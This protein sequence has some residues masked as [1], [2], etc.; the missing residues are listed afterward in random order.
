MSPTVTGRPL[1][2]AEQQ[3]LSD[4]QALFRPAD[5]MKRLDDF[6]KWIFTSIAVVGTLGAAFSNSAFGSLAGWGKVLFGL[7]I[8]L[9]GVSL[10]AST[11]ALEPK[12]VHANPS[13]RTS[14]LNAVNENLRRRRVPIQC[15][16]IL[17]GLA[18]VAAATAP[19]ASTFTGSKKPS[20]ILG[21]ELKADGKFTGI[22]SA[23]GL[24][25]RT[26]AELRIEGGG[27]SR[28][29]FAPSTR[30]P[31]DAH[32]EVSLSIDLDN[33]RDAGSELKLSSGWAD[34]PLD[35]A[36]E[37][38][39]HAQILSIPLPPSPSAIEQ[40]KGGSANVANK[41]KPPKKESASAGERKSSGAP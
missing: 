16:A 11:L 20:V 38:L 29:S 4:L 28:L 15:A 24:K 30:K 41:T 36:K 8:L 27:D 19:L 3:Q 26:V 9:V 22:L 34:S 25:P 1:S 33:A 6:A 39:P 13:S 21:Y 5:A 31:A 17:F 40:R 37:R 23:T 10:F 14:M 12:W 2:P 7:A 18:L 32:G 35:Q